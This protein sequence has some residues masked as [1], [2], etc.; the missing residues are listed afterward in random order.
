MKRRG[1]I[2]IRPLREALGIDRA[3]LA[4]ASGVSTS[5]IRFAEHGVLSERT[6]RLL[7]PHLGVS[8]AYLLPS[9]GKP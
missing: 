2:R 6:A 5:T 3:G 9:G 1:P 4:R 7:A 8:P